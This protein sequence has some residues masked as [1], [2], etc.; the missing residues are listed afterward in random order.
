MGF[1]IF[2]FIFHLKFV[3]LLVTLSNLHMATKTKTIIK[4]VHIDLSEDD[5]GF[6]NKKSILTNLILSLRKF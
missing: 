1:F 2:I 4:D 3:C 5:D 6:N